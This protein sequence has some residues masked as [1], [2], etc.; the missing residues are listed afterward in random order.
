MRGKKKKNPSNRAWTRRGWH[1]DGM[2][3]GVGV[4]SGDGRWR[5][6]SEE[7]DTGNKEV[8]LWIFTYF[9][10]KVFLSIITIAQNQHAHVLWTFY[11]I[12]ATH[13]LKTHSV[14]CSGRLC[15]I[16]CFISG[17][18][19]W[20]TSG[21]IWF[22]LQ[23]CISHV[24]ALRFHT[25]HNPLLQSQSRV[26]EAVAKEQSNSSGNQS[27]SACTVYAWHH[28]HNLC[29]L[30]LLTLKMAAKCFFLVFFSPVAAY[31]SGTLIF[32]CFHL[33]QNLMQQYKKKNKKT[34]ITK[35][36][37][38]TLPEQWCW[39]TTETVFFAW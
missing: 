21:Y 32:V 12:K 38:L 36:L 10:S 14:S 2:Q 1:R 20:F 9:T 6:R 31:W 23:P 17:G 19:H 37:R 22:H 11:W 25:E 35:L 8:E 27:T 33:K 24:N 30:K 16:L 28:F 34:S 15:H 18:C 5:E 13:H 39:N 29:K 3:W 4:V 7:K 26:N